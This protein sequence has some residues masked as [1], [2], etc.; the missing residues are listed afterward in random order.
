[1]VKLTLEEL[2]GRVLLEQSFMSNRSLEIAEQEVE[3]WQ[4]FL[5]VVASKLG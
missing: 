2:L 5:F 1:M 4:D 3:D